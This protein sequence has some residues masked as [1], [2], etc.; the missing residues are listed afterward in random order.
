MWEGETQKL[1]TFEM[2]KYKF[3][4]IKYRIA[5]YVGAWYG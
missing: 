1:G 5:L 4:L 2:H 3:S